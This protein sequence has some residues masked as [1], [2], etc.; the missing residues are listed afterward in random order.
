MGKA[1]LYVIKSPEDTKNLETLVLL[2]APPLISCDSV[3]PSVM[4]QDLRICPHASS[5]VLAV[6]F[7]NIGALSHIWWKVQ[8]HSQAHMHAHLLGIC[9]LSHT[10][11]LHSLMP[12]VFVSGSENFELQILLLPSHAA[13]ASN[14]SL[15]S[16]T[17]AFL[18]FPGLAHVFPRS[19]FLLWV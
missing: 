14:I 3:S 18:L 12:K 17:H 10:W 7:A 1:W 2:P 11:H 8:A 13:C 16:F 19:L 6:P 15:P 4:L 5:S 9:T